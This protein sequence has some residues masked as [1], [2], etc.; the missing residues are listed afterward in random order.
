MRAVLI[1]YSTGI[2]VDLLGKNN[3]EINEIIAG[4]EKANRRIASYL[5][6]NRDA[7]VLSDRKIRALGIAG[8]I[9]L[10]HNIELEIR[11][12]FIKSDSN[13]NWQEALYLLSTLSKH[14]TILPS[15][16]I[17]SSASYS[18][19][20]YEMAGRIL[21]YEYL[22]CRRKPIRQYRNQKIHD[23]SIEGDIDFSVVFERHPDGIQQ[24]LVRFDRLNAYNATIREAMRIVAPFTADI[25]TKN[26][27]S[28]AITEFGNQG[29][30]S[31]SRLT[32]PVRNREWKNAYD[33]SYDIINGLGVSLENGKLMAPGFIVDTW[34]LWEWLITLGMSKSNKTYKAVAQSQNLWGMKYVDGKKYNVNVYPDIEIYSKDLSGKTLFL[35][36]AKYK[37]LSTPK[38]GEIERADLYEAYA[39]CSATG[40][41]EIILV[42]PEEAKQSRD[43]GYVR[44]CSTYIVQNVKVHVAYVSFGSISEKGGIYAFSR[45]LQDGIAKIV[46]SNC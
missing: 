31:K 19:S 43:P 14:G 41:Q 4:I 7:L 24:S 30:P 36:D 15:E 10:T 46:N 42:Y 33:L 17:T 35:V 16:R 44:L 13:D 37:S 11:P 20:L 45:N 29:Y 1:E 12:K 34:Q 23:Y 27:L 22:A 38:T 9:Q 40:S 32:I 2:S 5:K 26:I 25:Q 21:A 39:F 28:S 6:I 18:N 8:V 3:A